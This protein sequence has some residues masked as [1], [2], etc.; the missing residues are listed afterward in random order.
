M[1][2]SVAA[3]RES[4]DQDPLDVFD[5]EDRV[6]QGLGRSIVDLLGEPGSFGFLRLDDPHL[7]VA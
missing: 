3:S 7:D 6:A 5:L 4:P 1:P 2:S